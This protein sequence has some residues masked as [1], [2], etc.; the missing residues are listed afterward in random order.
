MVGPATKA[1][2]KHMPWKR[3]V[4]R[5]SPALCAK[6]LKLLI[7]DACRD[8]MLKDGNFSLIKSLRVGFP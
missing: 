4:R 5:H 2:T 7:P 6:L 3:Y 1:R 8:N